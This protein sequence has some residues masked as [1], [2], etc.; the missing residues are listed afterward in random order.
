MVGQNLQRDGRK[1]GGGRRKGGRNREEGGRRKEGGKKEG[2]SCGPWGPEGFLGSSRAVPGWSRVVLGG[3]RGAPWGPP[4]AVWEFLGSPQGILGC[5]LGFGGARG[6]KTDDS[7]DLFLGLLAVFLGAI[8][9]Y[10]GWSFSN[11]KGSRETES[12]KS[13][14][15]QENHQT[16]TR[17]FTKS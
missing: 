17:I 10:K 8:S 1:E 9:M 3:S 14:K 16:T 5:L 4:G 12:G 13:V 7:E 11:K 15:K 2:P 6:A